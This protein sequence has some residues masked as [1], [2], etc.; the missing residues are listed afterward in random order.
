MKLFLVRHTTP[1]ISKDV[2]YGQSDLN[3]VANFGIEIEKVQSLLGDT[4]YGKVYSS[5]LFRCMTLARTLVP[6]S[7]QVSLDDRLMEF[8]FGDW[9]MKTW[10][11]IEKTPEA[12]AWFADYIQTP[13]PGGESFTQLIDR[14]QDFINE[15]KKNPDDDDVLIVTHLGVIRA[16][17]VIIKQID[18]KAAF[19]LHVGYGDLH[20]M[21]LKT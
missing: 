14:V 18:A 13:V 7:D 11:E 5:P 6:E 9:E 10:K 2:C 21:E 12:K 3:L 20:E 16:F 4:H 8:N 19:D 1:D 17:S 15:L